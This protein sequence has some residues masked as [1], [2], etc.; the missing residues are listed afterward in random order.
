MKST[1]LQ[2]AGILQCI[3]KSEENPTLNYPKV[4]LDVIKMLN[5]AAQ[6]QGSDR[7]DFLYIH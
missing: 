6:F 2:G 4:P 7:N 3:E 1:T 5:L